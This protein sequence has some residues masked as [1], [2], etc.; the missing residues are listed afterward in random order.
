VRRFMVAASTLQTAQI[1]A[2]CAV[3]PPRFPDKL[4]A[5]DLFEAYQ[6]AVQAV[7]QLD[8]AVSKHSLQT[9]MQ[10]VA[11]LTHQHQPPS[12]CMTL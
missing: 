2:Q 1:F 3:D 11:L 7:Q 6:G 12:S 8:K 4:G 10:G 5:M 9:D